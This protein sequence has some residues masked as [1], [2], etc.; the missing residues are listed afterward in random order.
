MFDEL[1]E[2]FAGNVNAAVDRETGLAPCLDPT[3]QHR[4]IGIAR[5]TQA[6]RG[7]LSQAAAGVA[8]HG[9]QIAPR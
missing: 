2:G 5:G 1:G 8:N 4:H 9:P 6:F 7:T 3:G